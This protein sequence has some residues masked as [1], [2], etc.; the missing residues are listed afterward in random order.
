MTAVI[1]DPRYRWIGP[2]VVGLALNGAFMCRSLRPVR[3]NNFHLDLII[4]E[5]NLDVIGDTTIDDIIIEWN[6]YHGRN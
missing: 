4:P 6:D 2:V 5:R 1:D 3:E